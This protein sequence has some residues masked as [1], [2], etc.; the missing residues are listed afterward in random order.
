MNQKK[1]MQAIESIC[2]TGCSSVNAII[3]TLESGKTVVGTEDF[4]EAEI[5]ELTI[6]LK[7]IMAVYENKN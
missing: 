2:S 4:T 3:K 6:E 1:V 7:S 5:N